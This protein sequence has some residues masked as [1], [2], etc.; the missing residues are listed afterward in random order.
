MNEQRTAC[1]VLILFALC[2]WPQVGF[3]ADVKDFFNVI[4]PT[5][6]DPWVIR[7]DDG[8][9]Y[10]TVTTVKDITL[11]RS[12]TLTGL[13]G[14]E[15]KIVWKPARRG[16]NSKNIWAPELHHLDGKWY[17]YYA[18]DDGE[19]ENHRMYVLEN[20]RRDP[21]QGQF[22]DKGKICDP[23]NDKWAIDGTVL[24]V[25]GK[26]Y[27]IWSGW[28]GDKNVRQNLYLAPIGNPWTI[29]GSRVEIS[30]PTHAWEMIGEPTVNEGPQVLIKGDLIHIVYSASG[31]WTDHY[32]L[33]MLTSKLDSDLMSPKSWTKSLSPV[34]RGA[35]GVISPGH[36]SFVTSPDGKEDWI[37]YHSA[38]FP[39]AAWN[40]NI[41]IQ[42]FR[43]SKEGFPQFDS[44]VSPHKPIALPSGESGR[45]R[46]EAENA[47]L[48]G[49]AKV[50]KSQFC[51]GGSAVE[52]PNDST[53]TVEFKVDVKKAGTYQLWIRHSNSSTDEKVATR[54]LTINEGIPISLSFD[55]TKRDF[56]S[57]CLAT[58]ELKAGA[59]QLR[60]SKGTSDVAVD[61]IDIVPMP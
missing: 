28:Q 33:G 3:G 9:Y 29:A 37:V 20:S 53:S 22:V 38:K 14:G 44:P 36:C 35:N 2:Y 10:M 47:T 51:S 41:R 15:K 59:N 25:K 30:R 57:V 11:W 55:F 1:R 48:T 4:A 18:A 50:V 43:F 23:K 5:G 32:C 26:R 13:G 42:P 7:H 52:L 8:Y 39:G 31:S 49:Q 61:C 46:L 21:F 58:V 54:Q 12:K 60:L 34:F 45:I 24:T 27:F 19:N 6:A 17:I 40:R 56:W 16:P